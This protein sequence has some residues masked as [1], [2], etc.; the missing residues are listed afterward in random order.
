MNRMRHTMQ[1]RKNGF[2]LV[3]M[4]IT[5]S[6]FAIAFIA[7]GAIVIGFSSAQSN[8][9]ESQ[10]LLNE[11]NFLLEAIA[12]EIRMSAID[13]SCGLDLATTHDYICLRSS[14]TGSIHIRFR[15][16]TSPS[17]L[18]ICSDS[19]SL[20]CTDTA[21]WTVLNPDFLRIN[22]VA[23]YTFP[24]ENPLAFDAHP[25][26]IYQPVTLILMEI[27]TGGGKRLQQFQLQTTVSS[28]IYNF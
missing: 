13:Y 28:R 2:T 4:L 18:E 27:E 8:A 10:R 20:P 3:E 15:Q 16:V 26:Q 17:T 1:K 14:D 22:N 21:D 25:D 12:R 5:V 19:D 11:G 9:S 6:I 24:T 7:I 23:F